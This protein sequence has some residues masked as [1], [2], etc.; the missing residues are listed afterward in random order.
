MV[1]YGGS[2]PIG[3]GAGGALT[4]ADGSIP[5]ASLWPKLSEL[6]YEGC[7]APVDLD[8][9][10]LSCPAIAVVNAGIGSHPLCVG[11]SYPFV[12]VVSENTNRHAINIPPE[13]HSDK[14]ES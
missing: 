6:S 12:L 7:I 11:I 14:L 13:K 8:A 9:P 10:T 3:T 1:V 2:P 4:N 5:K